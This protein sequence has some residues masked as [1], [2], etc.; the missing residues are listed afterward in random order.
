MESLVKKLEVLK[1]LIK[2]S[3]MPSLRSP[4]LALPK[5][6]KM[7]STAP[8]G[9]KN[10]IKVAEQVPHHDAKQF[11]MQQAHQQVK[12]NS[13]PMA[14]TA[15]SEGISLFHI[16]RDGQRITPEPVTLDHIH[17]NH[18]GVK[19][20]EDSGHQIVPVVQEE[21]HKHPNGQWSLRRR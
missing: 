18:G 4:G 2:I 13:N 12:A 10:P 19:D 17:Q 5:P 11:A 14:Y 16:M 6:P 3:L 21:L 9:K 20:L 8:K 15:K 1:D 7:P